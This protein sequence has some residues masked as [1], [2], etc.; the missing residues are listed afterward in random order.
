MLVIGYTQGGSPAH[1]HT[2]LATSDFQ[3]ELIML[4]YSTILYSTPST[5]H[6]QVIYAIAFSAG[7]NSLQVD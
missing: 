1:T 3:T 7:L 5:L 4:L 2:H 6:P